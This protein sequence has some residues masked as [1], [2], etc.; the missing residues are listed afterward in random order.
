MN[1][2]CDTIKCNYLKAGN[3]QYKGVDLESLLDDLR[4]STVPTIEMQNQ[5]EQLI[6]E[7]KQD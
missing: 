7:I 1:Q 6:D 4:P 5:I 2:M 3:I